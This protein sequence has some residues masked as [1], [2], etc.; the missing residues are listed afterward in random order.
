MSKY[1]MILKCVGCLKP[2]HPTRGRKQK[3]HSKKCY[4]D[5]VDF[6]KIVEKRRSYLGKQNPFYGKKHL[7]I[8]KDTLSKKRK[9][10][11]LEEKNP[12]WRGNEVSYSGIHMWIRKKLGKPANCHQCKI[13]N[14]KARDGRSYLQWANISGKYRRNP[15]DWFTLCPSCHA[16]Y[17]NARR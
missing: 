1:S 15:I 9:G 6:Q 2:F 7:K 10:K 14:K 16:H 12:S 3:Y 13:R 8:T 11:Y 4:W 5:N 17:D